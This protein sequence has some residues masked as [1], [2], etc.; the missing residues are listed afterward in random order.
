MWEI[1]FYHPKVY[2]ILIECMFCTLNYDHCYILHPNVKF[3]INLDENSKCKVQSII[4]S[5]V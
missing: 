2:H 3:A 1:T 5:I 4:K